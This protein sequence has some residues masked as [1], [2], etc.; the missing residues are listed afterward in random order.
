MISE[1][2]LSM[3]MNMYMDVDAEIY[4]SFKYSGTLMQ[5][6]F[7]HF[8][9]LISSRHP[10]QKAQYANIQKD[11][12]G[13]KDISKV[14]KQLL[15][16]VCFYRN[17]RA[18][19]IYGK[20]C[21]K[22]GKN[23]RRRFTHPINFKEKVKTHNTEIVIHATSYSDYCPYQGEILCKWIDMESR[24]IH[25]SKY[26]S[27]QA[28]INA[29]MRAILV[30]WLIDV[31]ITLKIEIATFILSVNILDQFL[32]KRAVRRGLLQLVGC[33][34]LL[35]ASKYEDI[36][37][38]EV[39]DFVRMSEK[40]YT[41]QQIV[42]ME[43]IM[44]GCIKLAMP[45]VYHFSTWY[46][47][48]CRDYLIYDEDRFLHLVNYFIGSAMLDITYLDID[49]NQLALV[50]IKL[51]SHFHRTSVNIYEHIHK[52]IGCIIPDHNYEWLNAIIKVQRNSKYKAIYKKY[53]SSI[54]KEVTKLVKVDVV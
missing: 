20:K 23:H 45:T 29:T 51:A 53:S 44:L 8:I 40:A 52:T 10:T 31:C 32:S 16:P 12:Y 28:D 46:L 27:R 13:P 26:M 3:Y 14:S 30:D 34:S 48:Y 5:H 54:Y 50:C 38:C 4:T 25:T 49:A 35:I 18:E 17:P 39:D 1:H 33:T 24:N 41:I 36:Y 21:Y 22:M 37:P 2:A 19:C 47:F 6:R 42:A 15:I 11:G 7:D 9:R 43:S